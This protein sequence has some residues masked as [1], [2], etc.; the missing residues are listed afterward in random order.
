MQSGGNDNLSYA[1]F[2]I[3]FILTGLTTLASSMNLLVLRLATINAEEQVQEKLE[4]AEAK[5]QAVHLEG[6]VI[7]PNGRL[8]VTQEVPEKCDTI[9]VCSCTCLDHK[10]WKGKRRSKNNST[11]YKANKVKRLAFSKYADVESCEKDFS[12]KVSNKFCFKRGTA[13]SKISLPEKRDIFNGRD[14]K[15]NGDIDDDD[16][17]CVGGGVQDALLNFSYLTKLKR[18]S[19]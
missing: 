19:I 4:A 15:N 8:L 14:N 18:N 3:F 9:S 10:I 1:C 2:T 12:D 17:N 16:D 6:D 5:R 7:S 11:N 13:S